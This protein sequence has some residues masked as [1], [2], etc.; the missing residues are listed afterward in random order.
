[1]L[2]KEPL[3]YYNRLRKHFPN[4]YLAEDNNQIII[5]IDADYIDATDYSYA[6]LEQYFQQQTPIAPFAGLFGVFAYELT[7]NISF[8]LLSLLMLKPTYTIL[9]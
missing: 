3:Y 6:A 5:G 7:L 2:T 9:K 8:R 1:M 4:S